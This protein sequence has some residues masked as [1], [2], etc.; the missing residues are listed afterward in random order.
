VAE[1]NPVNQKVILR[2]LAKM[3]YTADAVANGLEV[4]HALASIPYDLVL[5]DCQMPEMDGY[6]TTMELRRRSDGTGRIPIIALT[7]HAMEGDREKCFAAGMDDYVSKP[8]NVEELQTKL[9]HWLSRKPP[10]PRATAATVPTED[11]VDMR[12]LRN[13]ADGDTEFM[14]ELVELYFTDASHRIAALRHAVTSGAVTDVEQIAHTLAGSSVASGMRA[15]A[16]PLRKLEQMAR[17]G[18]LVDAATLVEEAATQLDRTRDFL[19][20]ALLS[21]SEQVAAVPG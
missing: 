9:A 14:N 15:V 19:A 13:V 16:P 6:A 20:S 18:Q 21:D 11:P 10:A 17:A 4:L 1:D 5:M 3:G 12:L 7:A 2:Q 8:V